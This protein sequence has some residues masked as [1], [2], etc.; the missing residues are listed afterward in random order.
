MH[1]WLLQ[2]V[3]GVVHNI[4]NNIVFHMRDLRLVSIFKWSINQCRE[5]D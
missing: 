1:M 2:D 5:F 3:I 4:R